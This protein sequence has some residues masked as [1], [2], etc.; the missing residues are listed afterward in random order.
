MDH[1]ATTPISPEAYDAMQRWL[2]PGTP[3]NASSV[4]AEGRAARD[5]VERARDQLASVIGA[6]AKEVVFCAGATEANHLAVR[7]RPGHVITT[8][9]EHP[10]V[11]A[12]VQATNCTI[13][14]VDS[15]GRVSLDGIASAM[16]DE[17]SLVSVLWANNETGVLQD[18]SAIATL[19]RERDVMLHVDA[20]QAFGRLPIDVVALGCDLAT[21]SAHKVYGP[22]GA[23]A[24]WIRRGVTVEPFITGGHQERGRRAGTENVAAIVGF[25]A[26]CTRIPESLA[27]QSRLARLR[28]QLFHGLSSHAEVH[29]NGDPEHC[30]ANTL[31]VSFAGIEGEA[32]LMGLDLSGVSVSSGS[33]CT[34]GS[35]DPS[36]VLLAMGVGDEAARGAVRF[37]LGAQTTAAEVDQTISLATE[38][39]DRMRRAA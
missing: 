32:M 38:V 8:A 19:C 33:A 10:S 4:H 15:R 24:L 37:S 27:D 29:R 16:T 36:H 25:G 13:V 21:F 3:Q 34:A 7:G 14:P 35:L 31:N 1:N 22:Q 17:T 12:A 9:V 20:V 6:Q 23:G 26:A 5:A 39:A 30:L 28:D 18:L 11:L 2:R